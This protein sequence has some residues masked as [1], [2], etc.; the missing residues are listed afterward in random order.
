[1]AF[2]AGS[3]M[4]IYYNTGPVGTPSYTALNCEVDATLTITHD[5]AGTTGKC[6][7]WKTSLY[8][9]RGWEISGSGHY[10]AGDAGVDQIRDDIMA[11]TQSLIQ[12]K[13]F[14]SEVY[15]GTVNTTSFEIGAT[16]DGAVSFSFAATGDGTLGVA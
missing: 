2:A 7:A 12:F 13:T 11:G 8:T 4:R 1:M 3:T 9:T 16:T 5:I 15:S 6:A 10:D 14:N